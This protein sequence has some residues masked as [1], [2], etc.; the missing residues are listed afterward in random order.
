M[1]LTWVVWV[2]FAVIGLVIW[3]LANAVG[4][5]IIRVDDLEDLP[6]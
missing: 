3:F 4:N 5:L 2:G 6:D 1:S